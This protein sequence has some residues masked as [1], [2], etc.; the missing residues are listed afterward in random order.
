M[1]ASPPEKLLEAFRLFDTE[2]K[3]YVDK[4]YL[5]KMLTEDGEQFTQ[6]ELEEMMAS[7]TDLTTDKIRYE[8]YLNQL[9]VFVFKIAHNNF[10]FCTSFH[11]STS[12][13][14]FALFTNWPI[15]SNPNQR[16]TK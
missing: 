16:S 2:G 14:Q 8:Y 3:G 10:H 9:M 15:N 4:D 13:N 5:G 6:E 7:A 11:F 12:Q 1:E